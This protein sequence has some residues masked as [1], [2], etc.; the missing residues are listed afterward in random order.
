M[1]DADQPKIYDPPNAPL[2]AQRSEV[3]ANFGRQ[4]S[5]RLDSAGG[6]WR[7]CSSPDT[8]VQLYVG[9][10]FLAPEH[11]RR[12]C[13]LIDSDSHPSPLYEKE[14]YEGVRTSYTC[15]LDPSDP[16]VAEVNARITNLLGLDPAFG[17]PLSGQ[18]Y[19]V[20]QQFK[21]HA[22]F[23]Y[24]DA[25]YWPLYEPQGGQRTWTAMIYLNKPESGGAT[26]FKHLNL[27]LEP[28]VGRILVWNNMAEDGSPNPWTLHEGQPVER[29]SKYIVTKWFRERTFVNV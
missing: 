25:A 28:A 1:A 26:G 6:L 5:A 8:R 2:A 9:N 3:R 11:C 16:L 20:G 22:D 7:L 12:I 18:R 24:I 13:E 27:A 10:N 21:E 14:K 29:G 23:F 4:V 17:E 15:N 19:E